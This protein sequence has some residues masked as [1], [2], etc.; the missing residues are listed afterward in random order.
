[1]NYKLTLTALLLTTFFASTDLVNAHDGRRMKVTV[2]NNQLFGQGYISGETP[3]DDG[4]GLVRPY[5][6]AVHGHFNNVGSSAAIATLPGFDIL[7]PAEDGLIGFDVTLTLLSGGKWAGA[8]TQDG[9]GLAQDFGTPELSNLTAAE[10]LFLGMNGAAGGFSTES[11]GAFT[12]GEALSGPVEDI[13]LTYEIDLQPTDTIYFLEWQL[14]TDNPG[15]ASSE[16]LY[17]ILSPDGANHVEKMHFQA[18][19]L[20]RHL[21]ISAVPEPGSISLLAFGVLALFSGRKRSS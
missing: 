11:P 16:S 17:T 7:T 4:G 14:S 15:I 3:T 6:N 19:A 20:E 18:L 5:Y 21:G 2:V 9:T 1:M 8:P 12:I 10:T 13:D